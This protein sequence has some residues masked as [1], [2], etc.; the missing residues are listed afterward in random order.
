MIRWKRSLMKYIL[1]NNLINK[2]KK[3]ELNNY[4]TQFVALSGTAALITAFINILK[5]MT[6]IKDGQAHIVS[7]FLNLIALVTLI[8]LNLF[9]PSTDINDLDRQAAQLA[10]VLLVV[11]AYITQLGISKLTHVVLK[12]TP[13]IGKTYS[14]G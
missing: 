8:Y 3:M 10:N 7:A 9:S 13:I 2:E 6:I 14:N 5:T 4:F 11:F 1:K 12:N